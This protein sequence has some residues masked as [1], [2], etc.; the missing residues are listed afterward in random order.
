MKVAIAGATG[1][2]GRHLCAALQEKRHTVVAL[3]R[4]PAK[5][6]RGTEAK[7]WD[8]KSADALKAATA[9]CDAIVNLVGANIF[10]K[11]WDPEFKRVLRASRIDATRA[12]VE[13]CKAEGGPKVLVNSSAI[14]YYG[15]RIATP[16]DEDGMGDQWNF[17]SSLCLEWE[18]EA[19]KAD[20][21]AR[22]VIVRTGVVLGRDGGAL[23]KM[24]PPF[25]SGFGG[26]IGK[27]EQFL[28]WI[29]ID[30][31][32]AM[33]MRALEDATWKGP[34]NATAPRALSN[35]DFS[36]VLAKVLRKPM[37]T[38]GIVNALALPIM[39]GEV[40]TLLTTGQNVVPKRALEAGFVFKF[41]D[42]E[43]ALRNLLGVPEAKSA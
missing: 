23:Q 33:F 40:A 18:Y 22:L 28:S 37:L 13:A 34:Y 16:V 36:K 29:H 19:R 7:A 21:P 38:P 32:A 43:S 24:L 41:P 14:G 10:E 39:L 9:G 20:P 42:L 2:V 15:P 27:G 3:T 12:C 31:L 6:P 17:L 25:R 26:P 35:A 30:D 1:F 8:A 4:E 5:A 11:K